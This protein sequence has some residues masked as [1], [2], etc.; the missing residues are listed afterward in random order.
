LEHGVHVLEYQNHFNHLKIAV[1]DERWSIHGSTNGNY[2]S[3]ENDK[4]F[5]LVV[6]V[7][8]EPFAR[9]ILERVREVDIARSRRFT[10]ADIHDAP[11]GFRIRHRDP[12]TM[13]LISRASL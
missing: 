4:D 10:V 11:G 9:N 6:L 7:D 2:R 12:R 13:L 3:L 1:F 5:E 8:D